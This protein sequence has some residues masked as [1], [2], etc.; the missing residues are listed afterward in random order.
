MKSSAPEGR[1]LLSG[2]WPVRRHNRPRGDPTRSTLSIP[3]LFA[4]LSIPSPRA[5][6]TP[7]AVAFVSVVTSPGRRHS[8]GF[9]C[10]YA[11]N[12]TLHIL[13]H[14]Y[15]FLYLHINDGFRDTLPPCPVSLDPSIRPPRAVERQLPVPQEHANRKYRPMVQVDAGCAEDPAPGRIACASWATSQSISPS[16]S[17]PLTPP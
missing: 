6:P 5:P 14:H 12:C 3:V 10:L 4:Y 13:H 15:N 1:R 16:E 17:V 11:P 7:S 2:R 9:H 8:Y